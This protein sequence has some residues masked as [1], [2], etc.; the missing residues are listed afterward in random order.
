MT[1]DK[2]KRGY[3]LT[4]IVW[5]ALFQGL[6]ALVVAPSPIV[7]IILVVIFGTLHL[8]CLIVAHSFKID[9]WNIAWVIVWLTLPAT[10][11]ASLVIN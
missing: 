7:A 11:I 8:T 2:A 6:L 4:P 3:K 9:D 10:Y 1:D 5:A